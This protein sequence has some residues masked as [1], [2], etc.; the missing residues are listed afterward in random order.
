M[1]T[2]G[3]LVVLLILLSGCGASQQQSQIGRYRIHASDEGTMLLDSV[4]GK[5]WLQVYAD[6]R[7]DKAPYWEPTARL[8]DRDEWKA[9]DALHPRDPD[10]SN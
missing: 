8:D 4:T 9:F 7:R 2:L 1:R 10:K 3:L 6:D 5:T